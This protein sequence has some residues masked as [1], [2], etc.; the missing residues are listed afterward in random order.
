MMHTGAARA[1]TV[2]RRAIDEATAT[3]VGAGVASPRGDAE[4]LAAHV[5]GTARGR[6]A[7]VDAL[8]DDFPDRY[9]E[10]VSARAQRAPLQHIIG[11]TA[12]GEVTLEVGPGVFV[13]RPET[14]VLLE[15]AMHQRLGRSP[16]IV[17]LC[18]GSGAL[19]VALA[20]HLPAAR[21]VA[22]DNSAD[23]LQYTRRNSAGTAVE[24]REGDVTD[25][26][27]FADLDGT[28]DLAVANPP[29][30]P[31]TAH[32]E[33][34]VAEHDPPAALFGGPDGMAVI[35]PIV[36]LATRW[37][38]PGGLLAVEHDETASEATKALLQ[39]AFDDI[40]DHT[41]LARRPRFVTARRKTR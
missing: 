8:S 17:D 10:L 1:A 24:V 41:D 39:A 20:R 13:P 32:V 22:V 33:P 25:P 9:A 16:V 18:T 34:E 6:L 38:K 5:L 37:L 21:V 4:E 36:A 11:T 15:W 30:L 14:E 27:L 26:T 19:A 35:K 12:F 29:Y 31:D 40:V 3:L 2:L 7:L 23:A 28:V